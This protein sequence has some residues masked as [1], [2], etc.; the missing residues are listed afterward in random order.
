MS[1]APQ[2]KAT[3][4]RDGISQLQRKSPILDPAYV[5]VDERSLGDLLLFAREFARNLVF[6][7][8]NNEP[9]GDWSG[10]L[11]ES[12][13]FRKNLVAWMEGSNTFSH[14]PILQAEL[15]RPHRVL[16]LAFLRQLQELQTQLN[17]FT[18]KHLD[19]YYRELLGFNPRKATPDQ[20]NV[21]VELNSNIGEFLLKA[22]T[23]LNAGKDQSG[24][25][26]IYLTEED[27]LL[28]QARVGE[29]KSL[30]VDKVI[31]T[32][33]TARK[34][35]G[36]DSDDGGFMDMLQVALGDPEPGDFLPVY[37]GN[38]V[39]WEV[40]K[41]LPNDWPAS[42]KPPESLPS[43]RYVEDQLFLNTDDF[44]FMIALQEEWAGTYD[45]EW[46]P[47]YDFLEKANFA[48]QIAARR[49]ILE[50]IRSAET[51]NSLGLK[52][53][54]EYSLGDPDPNDPLP[55]FKESQADL[56][57]QLKTALDGDD[58]AAALAYITD[59]MYM[60][61]ADFDALYSLKM[62]TSP[63][64]ADWDKAC[65]ILELAGR[66]KRGINP[67][68]PR[69]E[70]VRYIYAFPD[71]ESVVSDSGLIQ[72]E[73]GKWKT[74]GAPT[75]GTTHCPLG[76]AI[77]SPL[78]EMAEGERVCILTLGFE[79]EGFKP[80]RL[81]END[82]FTFSFS[83][84]KA[85]V[86]PVVESSGPGTYCTSNPY[87]LM[88][89]PPA[90][91]AG[92]K[93]KLSPGDAYSSS[94]KGQLVILNNGNI[95]QV[96]EIHSDT[97]AT[98]RE[99]GNLSEDFPPVSGFFPAGG[100][101][102]NGLRYRLSL[103]PTQP[104]VLPDPAG[105]VQSPWPLLSLELKNHEKNGSPYNRYQD[106]KD[107]D[108]NKV[109][110]KVEVK[111]IRDFGI[112]ND[113]T[114]PET[115]KPFTLLGNLPGAEN[116]FYLAGPEICRKRLDRLDLDLT[117]KGLP[118]ETLTR[119]YE[120][121][122]K[123]D[124]QAINGPYPITRAVVSTTSFR[125]TPIL[126]DRRT[127]QLLNPQG[128][129]GLALFSDK[130]S[131]TNAQSSLAVTTIPEVLAQNHPGFVYNPQPGLEAAEHPLDWNRHFKFQLRSPDFLH[132]IYPEISGKKVSLSF[133]QNGRNAT[134][135]DLRLPPPYTPEVSALSLG[136]TASLT[137]IPGKPTT[138]AGEEII[139]ILPFGNRRTFDAT[140]PP[141]HLLPQYPEQG[142][143]YL[144]IDGLNPP[145]NLSLLF[146]MVEGTADPGIAKP[147]VS[148]SV[149]GPNG[150][151]TLNENNIISDQTEGL[152][153]TGII[154]FSIPKEASQ[155]NPE[156][157]VGK[158]WIR[159]TVPDRTSA[160]PDT[161]AVQAQAV[162]ATFQDR[163][164]SASHFD[165]PLPPQSITGLVENLPEVEAVSQPWSS[166]KGKP[167][168]DLSIFYNRIS[169]RIR[170]KNR[171]LNLWDY[172]RMVLDN[173]PS[174]YK[175]K[176]IPGRLHNTKGLVRMVVI[177]DIRG[178][179]PFFPVEPKVPAATLAQI[180]EFLAANTP[181]WADIQ[182]KNP[183]FVRVKARFL[184][185]FR[186]PYNPGYFL[187]QLNED[188]KR[189]LSPWAYEEGA[190]IVLGG[191]IYPNAIV[192]FIENCPY[193]DYVAQLKLFQSAGDQPFRDVR[194]ISQGELAAVAT[195]PDMVL[196]TAQSH[197]IDLIPD[198]G[199]SQEEFQGIGFMKLGLDFLLT[200]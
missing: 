12:E 110:L 135:A 97:E 194:S 187:K 159:V 65:N 91:Y 30:F 108:L 131:K 39:T 72:E 35:A 32:I 134:W 143:L 8:E 88:A 122:P 109:H 31:T 103:D 104:P 83:S 181:A 167:S 139:H 152:R 111:G 156:M 129:N 165:Q 29:L 74:F 180:Q 126:V 154:R 64:Q 157:P 112:A 188:L 136:Y 169:E 145:Q 73:T 1:E 63:T 166:D 195:D 84:E 199:Y 191:K 11:G 179:H 71:A 9:A 114:L 33:S 6:Y 41:V 2:Y 46:E 160:I 147:P 164:N 120:N 15:A 123:V 68:S 137:I 182:V 56:L 95:Y 121:Y 43:V 14:D 93:L 102:L 177:P 38:P 105:A 16:F 25:D 54:L 113:E 155:S 66:Q 24:K 115:K 178:K 5:S 77:A 138:I 26:Q 118:E 21:L 183:V 17:Q 60:K 130:D 141:F 75:P 150:W 200:S 192:N 158:H 107:L 89:N 42:G 142:E 101:I 153:D 67:T 20:V 140:E 80:A 86:Y 162:L 90:S 163:E 7:N 196:V 62:A 49:Q 78:L 53:M 45:K 18:Q 189:Y 57:D 92:N 40:L 185:R 174:V 117:W 193:V 59:E 116:S 79:S 176:C 55:F 125:V 127:S 151:L 100:V 13:S 87:R 124:N 197:D 190:D 148:W 144:G 99:T 34:I 37:N 51:E 172:E 23:E 48:K 149:L 70:E 173:F 128:Q 81:Q 76:L 19:F 69:T 170:H 50:D 36:R 198:K 106:L 94:D 52:R 22:G 27:I 168:E 82:F 98:V 171:A 184:V 85:P 58:K 10:F 47:V 4:H 133:D 3:N 186:A 146:Q 28:N 175:A 44:R 61:Q 96:V 161:I 132:A 119:H